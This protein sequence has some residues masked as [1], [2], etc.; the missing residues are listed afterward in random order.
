MP[1]ELLAAWNGMSCMVSLYPWARSV[2]QDSLY[3]IWH[4]E[5]H[6]L[7]SAKNNRQTQAVCRATKRRYLAEV[8]S[9]DFSL[10]DLRPLC[11][12]GVVVLVA[13]SFLFVQ[14]LQSEGKDVEFKEKY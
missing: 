2:C 7:E 13:H 8:G 4:T 10:R 14:T 6:S 12:D 1:V 5:T 9:V 3:L 11:R